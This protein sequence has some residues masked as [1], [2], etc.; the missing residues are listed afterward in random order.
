MKY[1]KPMMDV[2]CFESDDIIRTSGEEEDL[3]SGTG[4]GDNIDPYSD[5]PYN[6]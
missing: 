5:D 4:G 2:V 3:G 6:Y 1:E